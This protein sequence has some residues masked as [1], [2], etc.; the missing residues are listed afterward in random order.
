M[1]VSFLFKKIQKGE[2]SNINSA[3]CLYDSATIYTN[4]NVF[5]M[6][7]TSSSFYVFFTNSKGEFSDRFPTKAQYNSPTIFTNCNIF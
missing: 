7:C 4:C 2:I 6:V 5:F 3:S 1:F